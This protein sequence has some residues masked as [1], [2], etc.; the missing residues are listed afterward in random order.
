M[1]IDACI[2]AI[3]QHVAGHGVGRVAV[4]DDTPE[5][6]GVEGGAHGHHQRHVVLDEEDASPAFAGDALENFAEAPGFFDVEARGGS[7]E[8]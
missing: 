8:K 5:V 7:V 4:E 2:A 6:Q 1:A 3:E